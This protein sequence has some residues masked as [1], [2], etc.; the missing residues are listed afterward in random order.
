MLSSV[1]DWTN[2]MTPA[3]VGSSTRTSLETLELIWKNLSVEGY[4]IT[5]ERALGLG[6]GF[7]ERVGPRYFNDKILRRY[8]ADMPVDRE[9]ARDVIGYRRHGEEV[10]LSEHS[11][12]AIEDRSG[13]PGRR[14]FDR[15]ELLADEDFAC[16][17]RLALGLI[18]PDRRTKE[19]TFGINLFRTYT[20]VVTKPH[21][22]QEEFI[23]VYVVNKLG[24]GAESWLYSRTTD[25]TVVHK[26]TLD[27]GDILVFE[28]AQF[29]HSTTPLVPA[30]GG[31]ARRDALICTVDYAREPA[32]S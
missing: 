24:G 7:R 12:V 14:E 20:N 25:D 26:Q 11:T 10:E 16:F 15:V 22:D 32:A 27:P 29:L 1:L 21:Q 30:A 9:R 3:S 2:R 5:N 19:G 28:D 4:A 8:E 13:H 6:G 18:P 17:I 23:F 31:G